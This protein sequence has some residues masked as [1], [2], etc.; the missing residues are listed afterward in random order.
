VVAFGLRYAIPAYVF[1]FVWCALGRRALEPRPGV[2][3]SAVA[4]VIVVVAASWVVELVALA[5]VVRSQ[6]TRLGAFQSKHL[7]S[8]QG[9]TGLAYQAGEIGY[10]TRADICDLGGL[11]SGREMARLSAHERLAACLARRP[12]FA[13]LDEAELRA[14]PAL[15]TWSDCGALEIVNLER[16]DRLHLRVRPGVA[17]PR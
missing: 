5:P 14:V 9:Q 4:A 12:A 15:A 1:A 17:C 16:T 2:R 6:R 10:F 8:L 11:V 3:R 13:Y 7:E